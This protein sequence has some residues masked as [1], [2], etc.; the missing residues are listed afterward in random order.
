MNPERNFLHD[1]ASPLTTLQLILENIV[2]VLEDKKLEDIEQCIEMA[3]KCLKQT[4]KMNEIL[5][6]RREVLIQEAESERA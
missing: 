3:N 2:S 5:Q 6:S 1:I 4:K